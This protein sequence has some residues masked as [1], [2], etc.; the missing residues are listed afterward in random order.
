M[1]EIVLNN[2]QNIDKKVEINN[3]NFS[4][5]LNDYIQKIIDLIIIKYS[6][7]D[8]KDNIINLISEH[9]NN[10]N[11]KFKKKKNHI[12]QDE[13]CQ[14]RKMDGTQCS[15]RCK[16]GT[17][18]CGSHL[19]NLT[20]GKINDGQIFSVKEKGKRGRKKKN[21]GNSNSNYIETWID[22][23]LGKCYLVDKNNLVY[24]NN[25]EYPELIGIKVNNSIK[26]INEIPSIIFE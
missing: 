1:N 6:L 16:E 26:Y 25:P 11:I 5:I 13:R 14:G 9:I 4:G 2:L 3:S 21:V 10:L 22:K 17:E 18:L 20:Y 23:D 8:E 15:R 12:S 24:K 7:V 19:K